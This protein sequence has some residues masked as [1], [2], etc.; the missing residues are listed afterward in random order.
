MVLESEGEPVGTF[1]GDN[2]IN[3]NSKCTTKQQ[4]TSGAATNANDIQFQAS[5]M[6]LLFK[7][8]QPK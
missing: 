5:I 6:G 1:R 2:N 7:V 8:K 4:A 3:I